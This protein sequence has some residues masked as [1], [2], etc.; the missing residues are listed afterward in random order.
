MITKAGTRVPAFVHTASNMNNTKY[1]VE[2][3]GVYDIIASYFA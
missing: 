3:F 1:L 2:A